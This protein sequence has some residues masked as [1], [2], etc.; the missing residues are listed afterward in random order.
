MK[1][2]KNR[3]H[4]CACGRAK[5]L[6]GTK[7]EAERFMEFN[8]AE[9]LDENGYAPIR[10]YYCK[11]CGGW[12]VTSAISLATPKLREMDKHLLKLRKYI[13]KNDTCKANIEYMKT[14]RFLSEAAEF[15]GEE[16]RKQDALM[17]LML[18]NEWFAHT[19]AA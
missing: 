11:S 18:C 4:C 13:R 7:E 6:F 14:Y 5:M 2:S 12:H 1:P 10:A 16:Q 9:I 3:V 19:N 17:E 8:A 15:Q